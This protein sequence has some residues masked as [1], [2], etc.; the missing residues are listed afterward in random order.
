MPKATI[1]VRI[2]ALPRAPDSLKEE[3]PIEPTKQQCQ[4][5]EDVT[6]S[7]LKPLR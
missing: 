5:A 7:E 4:R 1:D 6:E 2:E 3:P